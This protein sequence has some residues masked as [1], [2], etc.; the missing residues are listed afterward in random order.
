MR[1]FTLI[2]LV[3]TVAILGVVALAAAPLLEN[4]VRRD[5]EAALRSALREIRD[6]I[7]AY[8]RAAEDGRIAVEADESGYPP[9]LEDL[10]AGVVNVQDPAGGKLYFLRRLPRDPFSR[11]AAASAA[12]AWGKRS[13]ASPPD[14]PREGKDVY[15]IYSRAEGVGSNGIPYRAW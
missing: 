1:G 7:D 3:I 10:V 4:T 9:R 12:E 5:K 8:H 2:E 6:A 15:D 13:Y 11:E 14:D